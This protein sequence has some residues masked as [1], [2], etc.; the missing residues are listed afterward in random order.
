MI[1]S[2]RAIGLVA[3]AWLFLA[4]PLSG[5]DQGD[6]ERSGFWF[7]GNLGGGSAVF[8]S[9]PLEVS[10]TSTLIG[11]SFGRFLSDDL[12]VFGDL[13]GAVISGPTLEM[14]GRT[15][16]TDDDDVTATL[17]GFGVGAGYYVVP[18]SVFVGAAVGI[19]RLT[20]E[21]ESTNMEGN[22]DPG[23]GASVIVGK[24]FIISD[25][26]MLGAAGHAMVGTMKDQDSD[27]T[28]TARAF[29]L[30]F[31]FSYTGEGWRN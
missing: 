21:Q 10:G 27:D 14:G 5:Q 3:V 16:D 2:S 9:D 25:N 8:S 28:L 22:T 19:Q 17:T 23:V 18:S 26:W 4:A 24:D 15:V 7:R 31:T 11:L 6:R 30:S 13:H 1:G 20:I 12:V 29:G